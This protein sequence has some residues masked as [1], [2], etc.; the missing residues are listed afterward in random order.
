MDKQDT[1]Y[2]NGCAT[3][4]VSILELDNCTYCNKPIKEKA[5]KDNE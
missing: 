3:V 4:W 5:N 2:C 1:D